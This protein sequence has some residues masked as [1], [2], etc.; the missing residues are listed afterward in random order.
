MLFAGGRM[1]M[2]CFWEIDDGGKRTQVVVSWEI[3][4]WR[5]SYGESGTVLI[6]G[7]SMKR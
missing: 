5:V 6:A 2:K 4:W 7:G 3:I 1:K